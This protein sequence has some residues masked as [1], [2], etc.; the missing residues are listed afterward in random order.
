MA[1]YEFSLSKLYG[2]DRDRVVEMLW[3][4]LLDEGVEERGCYVTKY[5]NGAPIRL[6]DLAVKN[7]VDDAVYALRFVPDCGRDARMFA[8]W[9]ARQVQHLMA[10]PRSKRAVVLAERYAMGNATKEEVATSAADARKSAESEGCRGDESEEQRESAI[11][12]QLAAMAAE[13]AVSA[14]GF[15]E[16]TRWDE[17]GPGWGAVQSAV[18]GA[19]GA[20]EAAASAEWEASEGLNWSEATTPVT[21]CV[22][23]HPR[24]G[25]TYKAAMDAVL[26]VTAGDLQRDDAPAKAAADAW[27]VSGDADAAVAAYN[28]TAELQ[29]KNPSYWKLH[30][31]IL[32]CA[33]RAV[34][35]LKSGRDWHAKAAARSAATAACERNQTEMFISMCQGRAPWQ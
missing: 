4:P 10:D 16:F 8:A 30:H 28:A 21:G 31:V 3:N 35:S 1:C 20:V 12:R 13:A 27:A 24:Y 25:R 23:M 18:W 11:A 7:G 17:F 2:A 22:P 32:D 15:S 26:G 34:N 6:A 9:A 33:I 29:S 5:L 19:R 14:S